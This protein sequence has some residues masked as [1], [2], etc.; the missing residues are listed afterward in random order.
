[1]KNLKFCQNEEKIDKNIKKKKKLFLFF[2]S[3]SL[4]TDHEISENVLF[5]LERI[6][7][8]LKFPA[9]HL[10]TFPAL[11]RFATFTRQSPI[12]AAYSPPLIKTR[13]AIQ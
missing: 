2:F 10:V 8:N 3:C 4:L 6:Q 7:E 5:V 12:I 9:I 13:R 1:M 11:N